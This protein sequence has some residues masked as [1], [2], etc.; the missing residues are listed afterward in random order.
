MSSVKCLDSQI[1]DKYINIIQAIIKFVKSLFQ[2]CQM[3]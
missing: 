2:E 1:F 3:I